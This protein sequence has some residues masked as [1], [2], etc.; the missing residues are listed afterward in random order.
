MDFESLDAP[1]PGQHYRPE[2]SADLQF[3]QRTVPAFIVPAIGY[4]VLGVFSPFD[5]GVNLW[6]VVA[7]IVLPG[8]CGLILHSI[9]DAVATS[10]RARRGFT[11]A[12]CLFVIY[13]AVNMA[14]IH[15]RINDP[16][17]PNFLPAVMMSAVGYG[18]IAGI[19]AGIAA[20]L[21][22]HHHTEQGY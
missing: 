11:V 13:A 9:G 6:A 14:M 18:L 16:S 12:L 21:P 7:L 19:V 4:A 10:R 20:S 8:L 1:L 17:G 22:A 15:D 2:P 3:N 5:L